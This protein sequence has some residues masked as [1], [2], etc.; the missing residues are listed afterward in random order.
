MSTINLFDLAAESLLILHTHLERMQ[1][2]CE[3]VALTD[4]LGGDDAESHG[5]DSESQEDAFVDLLDGLSVFVDTIT[6]VRT[7]AT[8]DA[9]A[10]VEPLERSLLDTL[11]RLESC[12]Q[13]SASRGPLLEG[14][15]IG[16]LES[17]NLRGIPALLKGIEAQA[18]AVAAEILAARALPDPCPVV[19]LRRPGAGPSP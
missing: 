3:R 14:E 16:N 11:R 9:R 1:V 18:Q 13:H 12:Q 10:L 7:L 5:E 17:W 8:A 15:L 19:P 6:E 4:L 2:L